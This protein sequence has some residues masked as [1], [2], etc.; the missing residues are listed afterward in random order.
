MVCGGLVW[1]GFCDG[2]G[3]VVVEVVEV[4]EEVGG[5]GASPPATLFSLSSYRQHEP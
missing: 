4:V 5:S 1:C 2:G 3:C